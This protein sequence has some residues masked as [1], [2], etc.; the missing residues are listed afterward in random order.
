M[1]T[2]GT[3]YYTSTLSFDQATVGRATV[4]LIFRGRKPE[5]VRVYECLA[6]GIPHLLRNLSPVRAE[7]EIAEYIDVAENRAAQSAR[8]YLF[9][10]GATEPQ[11]V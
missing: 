5:W 9:R 11:A 10:R 6:G 7:A 2:L 1:Y 4:Q 3:G 8:I